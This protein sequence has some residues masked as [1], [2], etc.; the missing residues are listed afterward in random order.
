MKRGPVTKLTG[1]LFLSH[2]F[3]KIPLRPEKLKG[4]EEVEE[5][6][7]LEGLESLEGLEDL[8]WLEAPETL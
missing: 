8:E 3:C 4:L 7:N 6:E 5:L 1:P 2:S